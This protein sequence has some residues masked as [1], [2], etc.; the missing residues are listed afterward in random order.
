MTLK[1]FKE[2]PIIGSS[3]II[4]GFLLLY[5]SFYTNQIKKNQDD[6]NEIKEEIKK[7]RGK[8]DTQEKILNSLEEII[9]LKYVKEKWKRKVK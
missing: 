3:I 7:I 2:K 6:I 8:V 4:L 1:E 5:F 9:F